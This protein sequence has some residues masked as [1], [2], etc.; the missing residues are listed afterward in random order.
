MPPI[1]GGIFYGLF[2]LFVLLQGNKYIGFYWLGSIAIERKPL[3]VQSNLISARHLLAVSMQTKCN[4]PFLLSIKYLL[5][6]IALPISFILNL[7]GS[8]AITFC[9]SIYASFMRV[10]SRWNLRLLC[11]VIAWCYCYQSFPIFGC[12]LLRV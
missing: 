7:I 4:N 1:S 10:L 12:F 6:S 2:T 8:H 9:V 11:E 5:L 3:Q